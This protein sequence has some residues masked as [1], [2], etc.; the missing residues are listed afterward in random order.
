MHLKPTLL[1]TYQ[2]GMR[3]SKILK[4]MWDRVDVK[5]GAF[6]YAPRTPKHGKGGS[7]P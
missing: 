3:K 1:T 6:A 4:L 5:A 7:F 2:T